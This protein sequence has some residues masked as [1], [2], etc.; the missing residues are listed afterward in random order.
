VTQAIDLKDA[1]R[2]SVRTADV[3][4]NVAELELL[5]APGVSFVIPRDFTQLPQLKGRGIVELTIERADGSLAYVYPE[6][7]GPQPQ[8]RIEIVLDG[9]TAPITAGNFAVNVLNGVYDGKPI[10]VDFSSVLAGKDAL[11]GKLIPLEVLPAGEFDPV[12]R[13]PLSV[14]GGELPVL[15]LSIYGAVAMAHGQT[16]DDGYAAADE[17]FIY[18]FDRGSSGLAGLSFDEGTFGVFG[19]VTKG[20]D[21][22]SQIASDDV[23]VK[24][25]LVS[26]KDKLYIQS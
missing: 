22:V 15:P 8:A 3:L 11:Q 5:Q 13:S 2:T 26:G 7:G 17:F 4:K 25:T 1:D 20:I 16:A 10:K 24:A 9:Y 6:G 23:I 18:K 14:Q 19:Y 12:Y 21:L